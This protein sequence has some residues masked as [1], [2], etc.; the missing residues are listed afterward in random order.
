MSSAR[1][2]WLSREQQRSLAF[3]TGMRLGA[4]AAIAG[5]ATSAARGGGQGAPIDRLLVLVLSAFVASLVWGL[6]AG[7]WLARAAVRRFDALASIVEGIEGV[8]GGYT[9]WCPASMRDERGALVHGALARTESGEWALV[10]RDRTVISLGSRAPVQGARGL[11]WGAALLGAPCEPLLV[12]ERTV[13]V[14]RAWRV[15]GK[16][17]VR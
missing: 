12:G 8:E 5:C 13:Y 11:G 10:L 9:R 7:L 2:P 3:S 6:C 16:E 15:I 4:L 17:S 14:D 1:T